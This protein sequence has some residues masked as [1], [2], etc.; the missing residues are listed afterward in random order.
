M[1]NKKKAKFPGKLLSLSVLVLTFTITNPATS[2]AL[3]NAKF[4]KGINIAAADSSFAMKFSTRFQTLYDGELNLDNGDYVEKLLI[5]RARLKFE[6]FVYDPSLEFKVELGLSN[7]DI[8]GG[9]LKQNNNADN[10]ILDA[11]LKWN[12]YKHFEL[13]L[14][15]T[16]LPGNRERLVSSQKMQFVDRSYLNSYFNLDRDIGVQLTHWCQ[17]QQ[18]IFRETLSYSMG[19]GRDVTA[20]NAGGHD[21]TVRGEV[22]PFGEFESGGDYFGSDLAR[23][24]TPKLA[25]GVSY[26]L[27]K[28][29]SKEAGNLGRYLDANRDLSTVFVDGMFKYRGSSFMFEFAHKEAPDGPV[30][31]TDG[32]GNVTESY[33]TGNG[34]NLQGGYLFKNN[35]E[36]AGRYTHVSPEKKTQKADRDEITLGL[37]KYIVGHSLKIQSD[38]SLIQEDQEDDALRFRLQVEMAL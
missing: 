2:Q 35:F 32:L 26:D 3:V 19:E 37:S 5:R 6:G 12:F 18:V 14:G 25:I 33:D 34:V 21:Y 22:L 36:I 23:E 24:E 11:V 17:V 4:G 16:K 29:A 13:W 10:I 1:T 9:D 7:R 20:S 15:Q 31:A 30:V 8:G 28:G 38:V 27:N